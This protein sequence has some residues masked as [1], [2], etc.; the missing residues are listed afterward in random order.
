M[1]GEVMKWRKDKEVELK[2][3]H[4]DVR[5]KQVCYEKVRI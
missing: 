2:R 4:E 3:K 5:K 1:W